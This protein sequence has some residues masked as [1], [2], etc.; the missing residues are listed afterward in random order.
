MKLPLVLALSS[1]TVS[2]C[3]ASDI[4]P[5]EGTR[6]YHTDER[7]S[8]FRRSFLVHVP[9]G[10]TAD[11]PLPLVVVVHGAFS[12]AKKLERRSGFSDLADREGFVVLYPNGV[13]LFGLFRHWN[14]GHCCGKARR[15]G[16]DDVGFVMGLVDEVRA[17]L[18]I[19][20]DRVYLVGHSNGGML[21][22][23]I[24]ATRGA[25]LAAAAVVSGTIGG[26]PSP[27]EPEWIIPP[28]THPVPMLIIH[29]ADD[30]NIPF[31]AGRRSGGARWPRWTGRSRSG[32]APTTWNR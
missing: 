21:T 3:L 20:P 10:Y 13:G 22:H 4:L 2:W 14:G 12:S 11:E 26:H 6:K 31:G 27:D 1:V 16:I 28:P 24:A 9:T 23:R 25:E 19:D 30:P 29:G 5:V 15:A 17:G 7:V 18:A 32:G 8:G